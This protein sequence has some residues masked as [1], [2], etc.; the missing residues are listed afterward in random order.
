MRE[1][2]RQRRARRQE[3]GAAGRSFPRFAG[4]RRARD[5]RARCSPTPASTPAPYPIAAEFSA[6]GKTPILAAVDR[7]P[8]GVVAVADTIKDDSVAAI[9][10]LRR[11]GI[12]VVMITGD[13]ART[14]AA[15]ARQVGI[16]RVLAEVLPEH[17]PG[18]VRRLQ[19]EGRRVGMVGDGINDAPA[20]ARPTSAWRSAPVPMSPSRP[21]TSPSSRAPSL[22]S[23]P[24]SACRAPPCATSA[25]TCSSRSSTT[26]SASPSP[27]ARST[28]CSACA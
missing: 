24:P 21:P 26:P 13:N 7:R 16:G 3:V 2:H 11:L 12:D 23:S 18:E 5:L 4:Q 28:R 1:D 9:T 22:E 17:K 25:R 6:Q 14:A 8:A 20:V 27:Q 10:A 15:I 19:A